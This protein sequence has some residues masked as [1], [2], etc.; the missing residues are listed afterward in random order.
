MPGQEKIVSVTMAPASRL[1]NCR[2]RTVRIGM[3][4]FAQGVAVDDGGLGE[5]LGAGGADVV[6]AEL[7]EHGGAD[8]AGEDGGEAQGEGEGGEDQVEE[9]ISLR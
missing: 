9:E 1:P 5:A 6:L 7:F 4:A 2:P 8:H 3:R